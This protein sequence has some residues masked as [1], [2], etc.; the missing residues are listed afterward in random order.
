[1][2]SDRSD[3][4]TVLLAD[5]RTGKSYSLRDGKLEK[6]KAAATAKGRAHGVRIADAEGLVALLEQVTSD[7]SAVLIPGHFIGNDDEQPFEIVFEEDLAEVLGKEKGDPALAGIHLIDGDRVAARLKRGIEPCVWQLLD[8]D[9][10]EGMPPELAALDIAGRLA[11]MEKVRPGI[12][13]VER[14]EAR[15]SS[16]RIVPPGGVP[17]PASHAWIQVSD[18]ALVDLLRV[19]IQVEATLHRLSFLSPRRSRQT[20]EIVS[21]SRLTLFDLAVLVRGRIVFCSAPTITPAMAKA[22][23][24]VADAGVTVVNPGGGAL[25]ISSLTKPAPE[26]LATYREKTGEQLEVSGHGAAFA[27]VS[28]GVL[29]MTTA[30]ETDH[31]PVKTFG[32]AVKW[33]QG[34]PKGKH[35][36]CQTPFRDSVSEAAFIALDKHGEPFLHDVGTA[37]TYRLAERLDEPPT[38]DTEPDSDPAEQAAA[39]KTKRKKTR[40]AKPGDPKRAAP[41]SSTQQF[42]I[43]QLAEMFD[44]DTG[45]IDARDA[46][47]VRTE[48]QL[49]RITL[50][51]FNQ[52]FA[53]F[54]PGTNEVVL[55]LRKPGLAL[56]SIETF[57]R[58]YSR[59]RVEYNEVFWQLSSYWLT[60]PGAR[61]IEQV[62]FRPNEGQPDDPTVWNMAHSFITPKDGDEPAYFMRLIREAFAPAD[63]D[64]VLDWIADMVQNPTEKP[65]TVTA[66]T[67]K[68]YSGKTKLWEYVGRMLGRPLYHMVT[69]A[70]DLTNRFN[71]DSEGALLIFVDEAQADDL[72]R[73]LPKFKSLV[74][75]ETRRVERKRVDPITIANVVRLALACEHIPVLLSDD[76]MRRRCP[77]LAV[78]DIFANNDGFWKGFIAE[79]NGDGPA[80]LLH[81]LMARQITSTLHRPLDTLI[82]RETAKQHLPPLYRWLVECIEDNVLAQPAKTE[83]NADKGKT[84]ITPPPPWPTE[85]DAETLHTAFVEWF[86]AKRLQGE[87]AS[88]EALVAI[89]RNKFGATSQGRARF[90]GG[91]PR[92]M[93]T[94][95]DR[96][97]MALAIRAAWKI[98][99]D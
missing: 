80:R 47:A 35:L 84:I 44:C 42:A 16:A 68:P 29:N 41:G 22:G 56:T 93:W 66:I 5:K 57:V 65:G 43:D 67:G 14:A 33:L 17:G 81:H 7:P 36:R 6:G 76:G 30:I 62:V 69:G 53:L 74:T 3:T 19:H 18:P 99:P 46:P 82:A 92:T 50:E 83:W 9:V 26:R 95:L 58:R 4:V 32:D 78:L 1:M 61:K 38:H 24:S 55:D 96:D 11:L 63:G 37:T 15:S 98:D 88:R 23:W 52:R 54:Q 75:G 64:R 40:K 86:K 20:G 13:T 10:P 12:S 91:K 45:E 48:A 21:H 79:M 2:P 71:A 72:K 59:A 87:P 89:L 73:H 97:G 70:D 85:A 34:K 77:L 90:E 28:R 60:L 94:L 31:A 8:F 25:D 39:A 51:L 27:V 49:Q